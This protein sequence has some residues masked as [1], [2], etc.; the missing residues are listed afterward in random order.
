[1]SKTVL[2]SPSEIESKEKERAMAAYL[3]MF[4]TTAMGLPFPFL[5]FFA[6]WTYHHYTKRT[7][8]FV[9]FHSYQSLI[10]QF[11][12]SV[13]NGVAVVWAVFCFIGNDFTDAFLA[14]LILTVTVNLLYLILSVVAA[15][16]AYKGKMFYF[17]FFGKV[18]FKRAY[19]SYD[20]SEET[21]INK[22]PF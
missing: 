21:D 9:S 18:A 19:R 11:I 10:S 13:F 7:S 8:P 1:M 5:N 22:A 2:P 14:F 3:T 6:A 16:K 15:V 12:T 17:Y 4:A 20:E